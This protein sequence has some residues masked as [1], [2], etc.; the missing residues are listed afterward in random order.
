IT[1]QLFYTIGPL[2]NAGANSRVG[3]MVPTNVASEP[4]DGDQVKISYHAKLPVAWPKSKTA[5]ESWD[6]VVPRRADAAGLSAFN[7]AYDGKCGKN[8]YGRETFWHD[9]LPTADG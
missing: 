3:S 8:E 1:A 6:V 9:F 5:P 4:A 7:D 2:T